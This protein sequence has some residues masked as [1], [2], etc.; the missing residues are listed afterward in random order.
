M[1]SY[2]PNPAAIFKA[3]PANLIPRPNLREDPELRENASQTPLAEAL[4]LLCT[5]GGVSTGESDYVHA[6]YERAV[7]LTASTGSGA[8]WESLGTLETTFT[9]CPL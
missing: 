3:S 8:D 1:G 2:C 9:R 5:E 7:L 6:Y 4:A